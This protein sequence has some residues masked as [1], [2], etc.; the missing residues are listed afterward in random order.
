VKLIN[1]LG[2]CPPEKAL[3]IAQSHDLTMHAYKRGGRSGASSIWFRQSARW[4]RIPP[5]V[6]G[7]RHWGPC[8]CGGISPETVAA[9]LSAANRMARCVEIAELAPGKTIARYQLLRA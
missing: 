3:R 6:A 5:N 8:G 7:L 4:P 2:N 1:R 9:D